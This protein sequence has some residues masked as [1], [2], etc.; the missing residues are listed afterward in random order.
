MVAYKL[1]ENRESTIAPVIYDLGD[2]KKTGLNERKKSNT[3][4]KTEESL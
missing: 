4:V 1:K 3:H 2:G